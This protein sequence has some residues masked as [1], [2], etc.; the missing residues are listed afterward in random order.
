MQVYL[1]LEEP[2]IP[3]VTETGKKEREGGREGPAPWCRGHGQ[4]VQEV[5]GEKI[6]KVR[7]REPLHPS[8][9]LP[10]TPAVLTFYTGFSTLVTVLRVLG[11]N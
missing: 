4:E 8:H 10:Y 7:S 1:R 3:C 5:A 11:V 6:E 9:G 2:A